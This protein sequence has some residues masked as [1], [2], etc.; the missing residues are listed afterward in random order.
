[1]KKNILV[2][3]D[4]QMSV[5]LIMDAITQ[6]DIDYTCIPAPTCTDAEDLI[7]H[8]EPATVLVK[9][10]PDI[11]TRLEF[12]RKIKKSKRLRSTAVVAYANNVHYYNYLVRG[13]GADYCLETPK[14]SGDVIKALRVVLLLAPAV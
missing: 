13:H 5:Q 3:D 8:H 11:A 9:L 1:M 14:E 6:L 4:D 10:D 12:I 7:K 2:L